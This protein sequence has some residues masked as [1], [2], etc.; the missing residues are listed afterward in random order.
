MF[1]YRDEVYNPGEDNKGKA[2]LIIGKHRNGEIGT[3]NLAWI[4]KYTKYANAEYRSSD[5]GSQGN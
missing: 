3:I 5:T 4:G 1:L 2:E